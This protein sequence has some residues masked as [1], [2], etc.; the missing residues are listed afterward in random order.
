MNRSSRWRR[1]SD[2]RPDLVLFVALALAGCAAHIV[3][4]SNVPP[5]ARREAVASV[6]L[7]GDAGAPDSAGEPVL[8]ALSRSLAGRPDSTVI[9]FLG[10][11]VYPLGLPDSADRSFPEAVRRLEAQLGLARQVPVLFVPGN[12]DWNRSRRDGL[13]RIRRQGRFIARRSAGRAR[14]VPADGCPG[15]EAVD[16]GPG[17]RL[18]LLDTEWWLFPH[19][20]PREASGCEARTPAEV[21]GRLARLLRESA[22][23][24]VI[25]A[26]HHPLLS[27]GLHGGYFSLA[28]HF[29]P[30]RRV[31][32]ALVL[33]LPVVGSIYPV[34]RSFGVSAE[35]M[36]GAPYRR[37]RAALDSAFTCDP[38]AIY[39]AGHEHGLQLLD[40][41]RPPLLA[42]SGA[43][44]YG[45]TSHLMRIPETR[46]AL[47]KGGFIRADLLRDGRLR[48]GVITAT[49]GG[50]PR[51][52]YAQILPAV[53]PEGSG[54]CPDVTAPAGTP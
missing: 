17:L 9:L 50:E 54:R 35:D 18:L 32:P 15:P 11:N 20:K 41:G 38:P 34:A 27:G 21:T 46:L 44:V 8:Q 16:V 36:S 42:V 3:P 26:A 45:H 6:F 2:A 31:H 12:H 24:Q 40:R 37:L 7:I 1:V 30:L 19:Q 29:F 49:R 47:A 10:D 23:R 28:D 43:G 51:E 53:R 4:P 25:V 22:G 14:L 13:E 5:L 52:V 39:A 33:P 48:L